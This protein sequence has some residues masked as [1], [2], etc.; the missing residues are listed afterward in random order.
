MPSA[1]STKI[2][3]R[4]G[5]P[6]HEQAARLHCSARNSNTATSSTE[7]LVPFEIPGRAA[8]HP[9]ANRPLKNM[10][11]PALLRSIILSQVFARPKIASLG[12][13][14]MNRIAK[15]RQPFLDPDRNPVL[16]RILRATVYDH[17]CGGWKR[18]QIVNTLDNVKRCGYTGVILQYARE[19]VA[20][21]LAN[22]DPNVDISAQQIKQWHD[23]NLRTLSMVGPGDYMAVK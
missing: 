12:M 4:L 13:K 14:M 5:R 10:S 2:P 21:D 23:G 19:V 15:S 18:N 16:S 17:F 11:T 6:R 3:L 9:A 7:K 20:H 22:S 1:K 8:P